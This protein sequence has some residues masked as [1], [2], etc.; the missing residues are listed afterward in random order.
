MEEVMMDCGCVTVPMLMMKVLVYLVA[1]LFMVNRSVSEV[2]QPFDER[3]EPFD[4][5]IDWWRY[6]NDNVGLWAIGGLL[7]AMLASEL[8][9]YILMKYAE[10]PELAENSVELTSVAVMTLMGAKIFGN[11]KTGS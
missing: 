1:V 4:F 5:R 6:Y 8:G 11:F 2:K 9:H 10:W 7:G 3:K